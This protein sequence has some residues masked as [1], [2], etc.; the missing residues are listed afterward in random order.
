MGKPLLII[1]PGHGGKDPG[2]GTNSHWK[3]KDLVLLISLYQR[4]R[5]KAL[6]IPVVLTREDDRTL[7]PADRTKL[8]RESGAVFCI[9]NHIN[10]GG[11]RGWEI[12]HSIH[13]EGNL[14]K[15]IGREFEKLP[16]PKRRIFTRILKNS[17]NLD[18]YYMHRETGSVATNI[19]E[20]GFADNPQDTAYLLEHWQDMAEAVVKGFC[21]FVG[22]PYHLPEEKRKDQEQP[23]A[24][25]KQEAVQWLYDQGFL[26]GDDWKNDIEKPLPL[27]AEAI[28][29]RRMYEKL[30]GEK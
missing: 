6:N 11:G 26:T 10:A 18:Y 3:E 8:V 1:D 30:K 4:D 24:D 16:I 20:Y 14:A 23:P 9:S 15:E 19:I 28:I 13:D 22:E 12:I 2:G 7:E 17:P 29:L 27:W 21:E 5:F 25:W